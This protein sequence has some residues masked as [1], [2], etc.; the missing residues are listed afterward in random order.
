[1]LVAIRV[2]AQATC[3]AGAN[4]YTSALQGPREKPLL[5]VDRFCYHKAWHR[6]D[7]RE[8]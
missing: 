1:M 6:D 2:H 8:P 4:L 3:C 5:Y 7:E